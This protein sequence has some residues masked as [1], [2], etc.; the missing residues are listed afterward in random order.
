MSLHPALLEILTCGKSRS[1]CKRTSPSACPAEREGADGEPVRVI[2]NREVGREPRASEGCQRAREE[3]ETRCTGTIEFQGPLS[4]VLHGH[5]RKI[6]RRSAADTR[7]AAQRARPG[8]QKEGMPVPMPRGY[9]PLACAHV[10][11]DH[12]QARPQK[13]SPLSPTPSPQVKKDAS[14]HSGTE[15]KGKSLGGLHSTAPC[16]RLEI[17]LP[18]TIPAAEAV[19]AAD[20]GP[21]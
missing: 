3:L 16:A 13:L 1:S 8:S 5:A 21:P 20:A 15:C 14:P 4:A 11:A 19:S 18:A 10:S 12:A 6:S 2:H 17:L 9:G 7:C